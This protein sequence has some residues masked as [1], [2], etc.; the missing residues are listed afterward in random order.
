M[1]HGRHSVIPT[2]LVIG[3]DCDAWVALASNEHK[4]QHDQQYWISFMVLLKVASVEVQ[5][6]KV[7]GI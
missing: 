2:G 7:Q 6:A 5:T 3:T 4:K 1:R